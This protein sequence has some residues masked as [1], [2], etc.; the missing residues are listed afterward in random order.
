MYNA[1]TKVVAEG[2]FRSLWKGWVPNCQR[3]ALVNMAGK[4]EILML[5]S[6]QP[7][8]TFMFKV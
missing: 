7:M 5:F 4:C 6:S 8:D 1:V 2:G 3:A